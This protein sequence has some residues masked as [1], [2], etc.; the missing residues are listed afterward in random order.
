M[1]HL[2]F[3]GDDVG[4]LFGGTEGFLKKLPALPIT[5]GSDILARRIVAQLC[6]PNRLMRLAT[7]S[8]LR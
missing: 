5:A 7:M 6:S 2:G 8:R 4:V 1:H 3:A